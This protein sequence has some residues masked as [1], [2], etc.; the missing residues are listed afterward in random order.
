MKVG[1]LHHIMEKLSHVFVDGMWRTTVILMCLWLGVAWL[2]YGIVLLTTTL[3]QYDPHCDAAS[4]AFMS[5]GNSSNFSA[6]CESNQLSSSDYYKIML[7]SAA[8]LPG[9]FIT[10]FII[11]VLGRKWTMAVEFIGCMVG[12]LL[13]F[14]CTSENLLTFFLF[15]IRAFA[16]GAF[17]AIYVYHT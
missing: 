6:T 13:L 8:E 9:V 11:E 14:I 3:L 12:F 1:M 7:T 4:T 15:L 10:V 17:Q 2:Y 16:T 5:E